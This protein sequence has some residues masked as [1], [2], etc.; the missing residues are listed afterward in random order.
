M[1]PR[2]RSRR[3][4]LGQ[5]VGELL[6]RRR[7]GPRAGSAA[8]PRRP[9]RGPPRGAANRSREE[10]HRAAAVVAQG[11]GVAGELEVP[12]A[13]ARRGP[14]RPDAE[15]DEQRVALGERLPV[16]AARRRCAPATGAVT[17]WSRCA[18][19]SAGGAL[20]ELEAVGQ[21]DGDER[22]GRR[23]EQPL[24]RRR[25]RPSGASARRAGSR[26]SG[27]GRPS[28]SRRSTSTRVAPAPNRTTSRSFVVRQERPVQPKYSA[29]RRFVLPAPLGP[30]TT[31]S[32]SP[33]AT[34]AAA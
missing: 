10:L 2:S 24:D 6:R 22:A 31:V 14:P 25:R 8:P 13:A 17:T 15:A 1:K 29:S 27:R 28:S 18:R 16:G 30:C 12:G 26:R 33:S 23:V 3:Q 19:R 20:D 34:S 4:P 9:G 11:E 7:P 5:L 32:R 21:E